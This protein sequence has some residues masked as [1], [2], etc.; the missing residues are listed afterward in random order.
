MNG[1]RI[2]TLAT[3]FLMTTVI[4]PSM[5]WAADTEEEA[6]R[7]AFVSPENRAE[8]FRQSETYFPHRVAMPGDNVLQLPQSKF[9]RR[10]D[11]FYEW[12]GKVYSL[13][14]VIDAF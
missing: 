5:L 10:F 9:A 12:D 7:R 13:N 4:A 6:L 11:V 2:T 1:R 3:L 14:A 8:K